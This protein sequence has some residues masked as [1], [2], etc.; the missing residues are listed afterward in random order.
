MV[1]PNVVQ[2]IHRAKFRTVGEARSRESIDDIAQV[3][4]E[5]REDF[6]I[7]DGSRCGGDETE[8]VACWFTTHQIANI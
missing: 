7:V 3:V 1:A 5:R 4:I 2:L 6:T 8:G